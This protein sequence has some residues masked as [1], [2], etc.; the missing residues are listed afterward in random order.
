MFLHLLSVSIE[1]LHKREALNIEL[2]HKI[3]V[4]I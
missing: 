3:A 2:N 4:E 1:R